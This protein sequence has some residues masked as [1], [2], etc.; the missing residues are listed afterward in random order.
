MFHVVQQLMI[1]ESQ[2]DTD[3]K[4]LL[5]LVHMQIKF[6]FFPLEERQLHSELWIVLS[7]KLG[8]SMNIIELLTIMAIIITD[9]NQS[10]KKTKLV[11]VHTFHW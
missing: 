3:S 1:S 5:F 10:F 8:T 6:V 11:Y 7:H 2:R 9:A 4:N